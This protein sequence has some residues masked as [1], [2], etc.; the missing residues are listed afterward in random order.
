MI[1]KWFR[2]NLY[3]RFKIFHLGIRNPFRI[4]LNEASNSGFLE[5]GIPSSDGRAS[6]EIFFG[7]SAAG[8]FTFDDL[9]YMDT[10][11]NWNRVINSSSNS[12][13]MLGIAIG[14][15][16][17]VDGVLLRGFVRSSGYGFTAGS[18][19]YISNSLGAMTTSVGLVGSG[20]YARIVGYCTN[21]TTDVIYFNPDN[22]WVRKA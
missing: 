1:D 22:T 12:T 14:S 19:L 17:S 18:P 5:Y 13:R 2:C 7:G 16:P 15:N 6:G 11:G 3:I 20:D 9:I 4:G 21:N 10:S 8:S